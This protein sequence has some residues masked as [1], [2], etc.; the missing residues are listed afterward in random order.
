MDCCWETTVWWG[1]EGDSDVRVCVRGLDSS[2][3][4]RKGGNEEAK[5][6]GN[7]RGLSPAPSCK[8]P[9]TWYEFV[10]CVECSQDLLT[11]GLLP[12]SL[13]SR[14]AC[15]SGELGTLVR[16]ILARKFSASN[17]VASR[18]ACSCA[19]LC[20]AASVLGLYGSFLGDSAVDWDLVGK[21]DCNVLSLVTG[22]RSCACV[23]RD[24]PCCCCCC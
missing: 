17:R 13:C 5:V 7:V 23:E 10:E 14:V 6:T 3:L 4:L 1:V 22:G 9:T 21:C 19:S 2:L 18:V 12:S 20:L 8:L 16:F 11:G 24:I 15:R